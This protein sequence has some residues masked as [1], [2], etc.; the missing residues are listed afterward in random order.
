MKNKFNL[1]TMKVVFVVRVS[2]YLGFKAFGMTLFSLGLE[3]ATSH[4][5]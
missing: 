3:E 1:A 4:T 2:L 5:I